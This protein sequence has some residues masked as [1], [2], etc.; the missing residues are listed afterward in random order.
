M[1]VRWEYRGP[2]NAPISEA[3][4]DADTFIQFHPEI[5]ETRPLDGIGLNGKERTLHTFQLPEGKLQELT[6]KVLWEAFEAAFLTAIA[7]GSTTMVVT[8]PTWVPVA[9][10]VL[11]LGNI[12][13]KAIWK[14][15]PEAK[16]MHVRLVCPN[17]EVFEAVNTY[18]Q[19]TWE[20]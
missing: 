18:F 13:R 14:K 20:L 6:E 2:Q 16:L 1:G 11:V 10:L 12:A 7:T 5:S 4:W 15:H 17:F 19:G 9:I 3:D 8:L